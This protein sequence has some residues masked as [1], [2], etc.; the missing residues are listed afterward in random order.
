M[1]LSVYLLVDGVSVFELDVT[2]N[3]GKMA[4]K[5]GVYA[6][7]WRPEENHV[8]KAKELVEDLTDALFLL[9]SNSAFF[10]RF[11]PSNGWGTYEDFKWFLSEYLQ[12]CLAY[13]EA[14][15]SVHR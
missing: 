3:L 13:P 1:A 11:A 14:D 7:V 8:S 12:A 9:D 6:V 4:K 2:H 5:C 10:A 15:V